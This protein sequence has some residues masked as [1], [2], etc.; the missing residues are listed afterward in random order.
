ML[1]HNKSS[2]T[3]NYKVIRPRELLLLLNGTFLS[4]NH[5]ALSS[6]GLTSISSFIRAG[7]GL[8]SGSSTS[9]HTHTYTQS[10]SHLT[11]QL[12]PSQ[13]A[14]LNE[15]QAHSNKAEAISFFRLLTGGMHSPIH[16][17]VASL[18]S[19][20]GLL[21]WSSHA[22]YEAQGRVGTDSVVLLIT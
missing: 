6:C 2:L 11:T 22:L 16:E 7:A 4:V 10:F 17:I 15:S 8:Y 9:L 19:C 1:I 14:F 3:T 13:N 18:L 5:H 21:I 12:T 20:D